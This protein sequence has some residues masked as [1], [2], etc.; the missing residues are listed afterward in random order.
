MVR[1]VVARGRRQVAVQAGTRRVAMPTTSRCHRETFG[2][3][4]EQMQVA[5]ESHSTV[6]WGS[7]REHCRE[8]VTPGRSCCS[9]GVGTEGLKPSSRDERCP[10]PGPAGLCINE[11][12]VGKRD[13]IQLGEFEQDL[14]KGLFTHVDRTGENF[15]GE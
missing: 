1:A 7:Q 9:C 12:Q 5:S 2:D 8:E 14:I 4:P 3:A 10:E 15:K 13:H 11:A 6:L